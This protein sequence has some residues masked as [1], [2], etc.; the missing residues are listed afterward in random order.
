MITVKLGDELYADITVHQDEGED[1][2]SPE[3]LSFIS[4]AMKARLG[5]RG[6]ARWHE[7]EA[8]PDELSAV[9]DEVVAV[10]IADYEDRADYSFDPN[11]RKELRAMIRKYRKFVDEH[12]AG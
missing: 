10:L 8:T 6:R 5:R 11:E 1:M 3:C 2:F 9:I 12:T 4:K 7:L